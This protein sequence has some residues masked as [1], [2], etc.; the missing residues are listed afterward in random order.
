MQANP[1]QSAQLSSVPGSHFSQKPHLQCCPWK[2]PLLLWLKGN[3][4][5][6]TPRAGKSWFYRTLGSTWVSDSSLGLS[7][8]PCRRVIS[9]NLGD[10]M[11]KECSPTPSFMTNKIWIQPNQCSTPNL[12]CSLATF[13]WKANQKHAILPCNWPKCSTLYVNVTKCF[14]LVLW[15]STTSHTQISESQI[16]KRRALSKP[17]HSLSPHQWVRSMFCWANTSAH[18]IFTISEKHF[19]SAPCGGS[20]ER[21]PGLGFSWFH[22]CSSWS[23]E[24]VRN[25]LLC[26]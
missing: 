16:S 26:L 3:P 6:N 1:W 20:T 13:F 21:P 11:L 14:E 17:H 12:P 5:A 22:S 19:Q 25:L 15:S 23:N 2:Y 7:S 9:R 18:L 4:V 8:L 24:V 10:L